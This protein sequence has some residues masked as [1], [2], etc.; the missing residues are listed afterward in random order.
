M[1]LRNNELGFIIGISN[2]K[3]SD[4]ELKQII[5]SEIKMAKLGI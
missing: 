1:D 5:I 3:A 2:K 4:E